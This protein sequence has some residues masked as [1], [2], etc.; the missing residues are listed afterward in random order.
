M[1][2]I[3]VDAFDKAVPTFKTTYPTLP[4]PFLTCTNRTF[5][6]QEELYTHGRTAPG[7]IVTNARGGQ[8]PHNHLPS[9]AF[10]IA[11]IGLNKQLDWHEDLFKKF[12]DIIIAIE[13]RI[14]WGGSWKFKDSPHFQLRNYETYIIKK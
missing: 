4:Q 2:V 3:L 14:E 12:A 8:S 1:N 7:I 5:N 11:F 6:E 10:D 9:L 13:P